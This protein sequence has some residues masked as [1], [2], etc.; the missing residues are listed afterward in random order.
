MPESVRTFLESVSE[1]F[2][3]ESPIYEFGYGPTVDW[4]PA[5]PEH[6]PEEPAGRD[7]PEPVEIGRLEDLVELPFS[8]GIARTVVAAGALEH[9]FEPRGAVEEMTR[10]LAPGGLLVLCCSQSSEASRHLADRYWHPTP[11]AIQRLLAEFEATLVGW[12]GVSQSPH[13]VFGLASKRPA[14]D[15]FLAGVNY[16]LDRFQG[17]LRHAAA[18]NRWWRRLRR[19]LTG[20]ARPG[21]KP[22]TSSHRS[23]P[24]AADAP[25]QRRMGFAEARRFY[26]AQFVLHLPA[27]ERLKHRLL[28]GCLPEEHVG[29]RFDMSR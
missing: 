16:F 27:C 10:I 18:Q 28:A 9:V 4:F 24:K 13:S 6:G 23:T 19:R 7:E 25:P 20:W 1:A 17:R 14:A 21:W 12:Q 29:S 15:A 8:D 11:Q 22:A 3:L 5:A 2:R 26:H